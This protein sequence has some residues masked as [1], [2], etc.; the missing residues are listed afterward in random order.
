MISSITKKIASA[1]HSPGVYFFLDDHKRVLY[2]GKATNLHAR[3]SSYARAHTL[4]ARKQKMIHDATGLKWKV[5]SSDI[6][7]LIEEASYIKKLHP[8]YN[9]LL[10]DDK[11]YLFVAITRDS[12][13]RI[14]TTHQTAVTKSQEAGD[15]RQENKKLQTELIGPFTSAGAVHVVLKKLRNIYPYCT[16]V[17]KSHT[18]MCVND[19]IG[20]CIGVCCLNPKLI[21]SQTDHSLNSARRN[22]LKNI[23][24]IRALLLGKHRAIERTVK[25][26]MLQASRAKDYERAARARD[27]LA[28]LDRVFAHQ[29]FVKQ[30]TM[31]DRAKALRVLKDIAGLST[32][33]ER[34]EGY[35]ISH[36]QGVEKVGSMVVFINGEPATSQY[37]RF[38]IR[39]VTGSND[40]ASHY[41]VLSRRLKHKE[42]PMADFLLIDGGA[43]Q[44]SA[45]LQALKKS[46]RHIPIGA[47]A[48]REEELYL[49]DQ[50]P[51]KLRDLSPSLELLLRHV[52]DESHRFALSL[53]RKRRAKEFR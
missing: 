1:P 51:I 10:Q 27:E 8:P 53:H 41:E 16:C 45:T 6:E 21:N 28:A 42:W 7:A 25:K 50:K 37:R 12:F 23:A 2:V 31:T 52:R 29:Q 36:T 4:D 44:L 18:R 43:P 17:G 5:L 46:G 9:V 24:R 19:E 39:S 14:Y 15:K 47:I 35:D 3:L 20:K 38:I 11:N 33:P 32:V 49:P 26:E 13:P 34:I 30:D 22:Y 48:K 40:V